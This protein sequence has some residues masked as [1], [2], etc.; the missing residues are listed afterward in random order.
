MN[1]AQVWLLAIRYC[2]LG[3]S[4]VITTQNMTTDSH[5]SLVAA[6][7]EIESLNLNSTMSLQMYVHI[8]HIEPNISLYLTGHFYGTGCC[9]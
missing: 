5:K 3:N 7:I 9:S 2:S 4:I 1:K 8:L 6:A